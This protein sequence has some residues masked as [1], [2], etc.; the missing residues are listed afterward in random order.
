[1]LHSLVLLVLLTLILVIV[2]YDHGAPGRHARLDRRQEGES[3]EGR[4]RKL[5]ALEEGAELSTLRVVEARV[6]ERTAS[7]IAS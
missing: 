2:D 3:G 5:E 7:C 1:L 6:C 4:A